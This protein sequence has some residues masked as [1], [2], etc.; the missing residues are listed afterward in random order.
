MAT[1]QNPIIILGA[2]ISGLALAQALHQRN[3][4]FRIY[5]RDPIF[6]LR[7]QGYRVR[8]SG[9]GITALRT[10]LPAE[11]YSRLEK[12]CA[13]QI[14]GEKPGPRFQLDALTAEEHVGLAMGPPPR[15]KGPGGPI[16]HDPRQAYDVAPLNADR[17]VLRNVLMH[18]MEP[19]TEFGKEFASYEITPEGVKVRFSDGSEAEGCLLVGA[20]GAG[21][22]VRKQLLPES[23]LL[24]TEGRFIYG[25]TTLTPELEE[26]FQEK[27][28]QGMTVVHDNSQAAKTTLLLEPI[29]F[30]DNEFRK[31]LP[32]NYIYWV[33]ISRKDRYE[34]DDSKL[35]K[36]SNPES[37]A[38]AQESTAHWHSSFRPLFEAQDTEKIAMIRIISATPDIPIWDGMGKVTLI[39]DAAHVMSPTAGI[40]ATTA[41]KDTAKLGDVLEQGGR[42]SS[43]SYA[44][45]LKEYEEA[46]REWAKAALLGSQM[47]G[48]H[49]FGMPPFEELKEIN[50]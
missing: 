22:R 31:D 8:I 13:I 10:C 30:K 43:G 1:Q 19:Y 33:L 9:P 37:A 26:K 35:L 48:K 38:L 2:G 28:L 17:T 7:A 25:K 47:G 36:L 5:E 40:G 21:S 18:G 23:R 50:A 14:G 11:L 39:G 49:L 42:D 15:V 20:D 3:I 41:L 6:N 46:M 45:S 24:D 4:P 29:R 32:P 27:C 34:I 44:E 16:V 12:S